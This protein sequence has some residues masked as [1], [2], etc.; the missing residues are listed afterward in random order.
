MCIVEVVADKIVRVYL[1][2]L[3]RSS[4]EKQ[5]VEVFSY[6]CSPAV[7]EKSVTDFLKTEA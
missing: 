2:Y 7:I 5:H 1:T 4:S 3:I 6:R